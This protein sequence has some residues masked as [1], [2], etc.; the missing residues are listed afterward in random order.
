MTGF[1]KRK[2]METMIQ[3][4]FNLKNKRNLKKDSSMY[5]CQQIM[6]ISY[7]LYTMYCFMLYVK[8]YVIYYVLYKAHKMLMK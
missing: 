8:F 6:V 7:L 5:N 4:Y 1:A 3:V 2:G